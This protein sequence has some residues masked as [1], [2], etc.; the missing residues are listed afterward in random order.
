M[1]KSLVSL[2]GMRIAIL[3]CG[4]LTLIMFAGAQS[5]PPVPGPNKTSQ[6]HQEHRDNV[7]G[8]QGTDTNAPQ[9]SLPPSPAPPQI[10]VTQQITD[11]PAGKAR[12][13]SASDWWV[14]GFTGCLVIVAV[15]QFIAMCRQSA[16]MRRGL[17]ISMRQAHIASRNALAAKVNAEAAEKSVTTMSDQAHVM[18]G[19][20]RTMKDSLHETRRAADAA[21][22]SAQAAKVSADALIGAERPWLFILVPEGATIFPFSFSFK[23]YGRTPA[24]LIELKYDYRRFVPGAMRGPINYAFMGNRIQ[25]GNSV[26]VLPNEQT[27]Q[28][29]AK[30]ESS[31]LVSEA[32]GAAWMSGKFSADFFGIIKYRDIFEKERETR[33]CYTC[34]PKVGLVFSG[35]P[36]ANKWT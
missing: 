3:I 9:A 5:P 23:N 27:G 15:L 24:W 1:R 13:K 10:R 7:T 25:G 30:F 12:D 20:W 19:Q 18:Q 36:E 8:K 26:P 2:S 33:F 31:V 11:D 22:V 16:H 29:T 21:H 4:A 14:A 6:S 28:L 35:P 32:E 34:L 17:K